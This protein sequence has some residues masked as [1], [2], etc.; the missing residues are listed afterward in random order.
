MVVNQDH[1]MTPI[2]MCQQRDQA[3]TSQVS[4][5]VLEDDN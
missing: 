1:L 4:T 2:N 5:I 3:L